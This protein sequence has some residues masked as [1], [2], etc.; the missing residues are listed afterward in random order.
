MLKKSQD[1]PRTRTKK[2]AAAGPPVPL[3]FRRGARKI[4]GPA[5]VGSGRKNGWK[6]EL[7][8]GTICVFFFRDFIA[9]L[10]GFWRIVVILADFTAKCREFLG[11][12]LPK[13]G[14][15]RSI[16]RTMGVDPAMGMQ[17]SIEEFI[18]S[19]GNEDANPVVGEV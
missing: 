2:A 3:P 16:S 1:S 10:G 13:M 6:R 8:V 19:I 14:S 7:E 4:R 9:K 5:W 18:S 11:I 15:F 17:L 12:S